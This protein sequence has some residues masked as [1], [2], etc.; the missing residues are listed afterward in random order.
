MTGRQ[1][2][3]NLTKMSEKNRDKKSMWALLISIVAL[4]LCLFVFALW[5]FEVIPHSVITL[6]SFIGACVSL[7]AVIVTLAIGSQIVN[8]MEVKSAQRKYEE[9]LKTALEKIQQHQ[10]QIEEEQHRNSHLHNC[11]IAKSMQDDRQFGK[12]CFYYTCALYEYMQMK[13]QLGNEVYIFKEM[14]NC[15]TKKDGN[16]KISE[17][18]QAELRN[19]DQLL[20]KTPNYHWIK[21][22]YETL[23]LEFQK[24]MN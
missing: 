9:E 19:V 11:N 2:T 22:Q 6:D 17:K 15:L 10:V 18:M 3:R 14:H 13:T 20:R 7:V 4:L 16:W 12:A 8:V 1:K 5:V 21:G 24:W 23:W